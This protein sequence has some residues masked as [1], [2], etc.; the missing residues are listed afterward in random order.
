MLTCFAFFS[1]EG[2]SLLIEY[3]WKIKRRRAIP[4]VFVSDKEKGLLHIL[5]VDGSIYSLYIPW[6]AKVINSARRTLHLESSCYPVV[7]A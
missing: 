3:I 7:G 2:F 6:E 5:E 4:V 1:A